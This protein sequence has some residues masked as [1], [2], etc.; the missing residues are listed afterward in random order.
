MAT[1]FS[2]NTAFKAQDK[3]SKVFKKMGRSSSVFGSLLKANL[4]GS[5]ITGAFNSFK[6]SISA[7]LDGL[8]DLE[9]AMA[10]V[11]TIADTNVISLQDQTKAVLKLSNATGIAATEISEAQYQAISAGVDTA[12]SIDFVNVALK[13]SVGGFTDTTTA[14]D[15]LTTVLNAYNMTA[16]DSVMVADQM[17]ATQN[18]GKTTF[19]DMAQK[20]GEVIPIASTLNVK[21]YELFGSIA[22]L[23][24]QGIKTPQAMT[25]I[26]AALSNILKPAEQAVKLSD[27]L[28]L[29]FN[30]AALASKGLA[31]FLDDVRLKTGGS[32][33]KMAK[34][35]GSVE[36]L[37]TVMALSKNN[38]EDLS[39]ALD[40]IKN[41]SGSL[42][43]AFSQMSDT[44]GFR[45]ARVKNRFTNLSVSML[46]SLSPLLDMLLDIAEK[47]NFDALSAQLSKFM[48]GLNLEGIAD[49]MIQFIDEGISKIPVIV[50]SMA[51]MM[52]MIKE[53]ATQMGLVVS[54][55]ADGIAKLASMGQGPV[56][57]TLK[58]LATGGV[59]GAVKRKMAGDEETTEA[60][61]AR[62]EEARAQTTTTNI[63]IMLDKE[64]K[65]RQDASRSRGAPNVNIASMGAN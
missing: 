16:E 41:S 43:M 51:E 9:T 3:M 49:K 39:F 26:K 13:A 63:Q 7:G 47:V 17:L 65:A 25:G 22:A 6:N 1:N 30:S 2:V 37:N 42:D 62:V 34:L 20:L 28:G 54:F 29:E 8:I 57:K 27:S 21:T 45:F 46:D 33:E 55:I 64:L 14:V 61:N 50:S 4:A 32:Q 44:M 36:A 18:L 24:K 52:P 35:F 23:T 15:G 59:L 11:G 38:G 58:F 12:K 48:S 10:K 56:F 60:P 31:G 40:A 5:L 19:G 53:F